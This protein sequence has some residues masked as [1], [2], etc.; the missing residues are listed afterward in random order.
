M[1]GSTGATR[2]VAR[3]TFE[4]LMQLLAGH[5]DL[6]PDRVRERIESPQR[7]RPR[8]EALRPR[9][10]GEVVQLLEVKV[11]TRVEARRSLR[12]K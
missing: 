9:T 8:A 12:L 5:P 11:T 1:T 7:R 6:T 3:E 10:A 4:A 2:H